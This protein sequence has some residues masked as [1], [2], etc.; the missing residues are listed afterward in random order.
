MNEYHKIQLRDNSP[1]MWEEYTG[2]LHFLY[3]PYRNA[4]T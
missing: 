3:K 2:T 4:D 1:W